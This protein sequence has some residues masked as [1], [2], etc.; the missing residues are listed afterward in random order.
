[1]TT[2]STPQFTSDTAGR[3]QPTI[4]LVD[5]YVVHR[6]RS[7][8]L[9][10]PDTIRAVDGVSVSVRR[11]EVLGIVG[12]SGSGKSTLARVMTGLQPVTSGHVFFDGQPLRRG[13]TA[14]KQLGRKVSV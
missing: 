4:E 1:M 9:L 8:S 11:G 3:E 13:G 12:E 2:D 6:L 10:H 5:V 14:S 7:G